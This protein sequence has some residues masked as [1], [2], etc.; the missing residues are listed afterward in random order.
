VAAAHFPLSFV[1]CTRVSG[2]DVVATWST[3]GPV[4]P[5]RRVHPFYFTHV[6]RVRGTAA[7]SS[8][9]MCRRACARFASPLS[10]QFT[11]LFGL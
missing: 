8:R 9:H 3:V 2:K 7:L 1:L 4:L 5:A 6:D 10:L 11:T